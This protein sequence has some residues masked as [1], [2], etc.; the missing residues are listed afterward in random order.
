MLPLIASTNGAT[1]FFWEY[2]AMSTWFVKQIASVVTIEPCSTE[3]NLQ[4]MWAKYA[5]I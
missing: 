4:K 2:E 1:N 3:K 5:N